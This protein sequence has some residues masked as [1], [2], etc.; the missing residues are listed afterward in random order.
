MILQRNRSIIRRSVSSQT[1]VIT[2]VPQQFPP[3][4]V[5]HLKANRTKSIPHTFDK[6]P[7]TDWY[8]VQHVIFNRHL[9]RTFFKH[10]VTVT[11]SFTDAVVNFTHVRVKSFT[12]LI[13]KTSQRHSVVHKLTNDL[14][15]TFSFKRQ[16][17]HK[18][19]QCTKVSFTGN[20]TSN[21]QCNG[22]KVLFCPLRTHQLH[23]VANVSN[24][25]KHQVKRFK[26]IVTNPGVTNLDATR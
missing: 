5:I 10:Q 26:G 11:Q 9:E 13:T 3:R 1:Q 18:L 19:S 22:S 21:S 6:V 2:A 25:S 14:F 24:G 7:F 23:V 12:Q 15:T 16:S 20:S 8:T 4:T 17:I